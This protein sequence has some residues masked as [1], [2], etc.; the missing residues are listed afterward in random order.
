LEIFNGFG[1][2]PAVIYFDDERKTANVAFWIAQFVGAILFIVTW[3]IAPLVGTFFNDIRAVPVIRLLAFN[4]PITALRIVHDALLQKELAFSRWI[5]PDLILSIGKGIISIVLAVLGYGVWSLVVGYIIGNILSVIAFWLVMPWRPSF[6]IDQRLLRPLF[7]YGTNII[8]WEFLNVILNE[9]DY[10]LVGHYLG[11]VALGIYTMA[12]RIPDMLIIQFNY[13]ISRVIFPT[14]TKVKD[15]N[16][17][18][19]AVFLNT[20]KYMTLI[21]TPLGIGMAIIA[22]PLVLVVLSEKWIDVYPVLQAI[23][24][25]ATMLSLSH[26]AGDI[27]KAQGRPIIVVQI[28]AVRALMLVPGLWWATSFQKSIISVGWVHVIVATLAAIVSLAIASRMIKVSIKNILDAL[29]PAFSGAIVM[30]GVVWIVLNLLSTKLPII[31]LVAGILTGALSYFLVLW[32]L[33]R[34]VV[35]TSFRVLKGSLM[36]TKGI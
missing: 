19:A 11:S 33:C 35:M 5:I 14:F 13:T 20:L 34:D 28:S 36:R 6:N 10:L 7:S 17:I 12:F 21:T 9:S 8:S 27:Y 18:L 15:N 25:Y 23:A 29:S 1:L 26:H 2:L 3:N 16:Q 30:A 24:I 32:I 31:Q 4:F 22:R